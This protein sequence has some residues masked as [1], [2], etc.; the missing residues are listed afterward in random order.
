[1]IACLVAPKE[2]YFIHSVEG[3]SHDFED[4]CS[5]IFHNFFGRFGF[6]QFFCSL[7]LPHLHPMAWVLYNPLHF[8]VRNPA[9]K[10]CLNSHL[11]TKT[12]CTPSEL[13]LLRNSTHV[14]CTRGRGILIFGGVLKAIFK[15]CQR[16]GWRLWQSPGAQAGSWSADSCPEGRHSPT[17]KLAF[18]GSQ[19]PSHRLEL[20]CKVTLIQNQAVRPALRPPQFPQ[21]PGWT[22]L[23]GL[24]RKTS[25]EGARRAPG[26]YLAA[27]GAAIPRSLRGSMP[28]RPSYSRRSTTCATARLAGAHP[29]RR[30]P[31]CGAAG[32][33]RAGRPWVGA[34]REGLGCARSP[35]PTLQYRLKSWGRL[36]RCEKSSRWPQ[37]LTLG[38]RGT[39]AWDRVAVRGSSEPAGG[40]GAPTLRPEQPAP[41]GGGTRR[42][43]APGET[44]GW[45]ERPAGRLTPALMMVWRG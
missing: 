23:G 4:R 14:P 10:C 11:Q 8:Q 25:G 35:T 9:G 13:T 1:M 31:P 18:P 16:Q 39:A 2:P 33:R 26:T 21:G 7:L 20:W 3:S 22:G 5:E 34:S 36:G 17:P 44:R 42:L 15:A 41:L 32:Q 27:A 19:P 38:P 43:W 37:D 28:A 24:P 45:Q 29:Q 40:G 6:S 12:S 30:L